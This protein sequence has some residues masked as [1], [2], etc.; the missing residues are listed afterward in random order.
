MALAKAASHVDVV[1]TTPLAGTDLSLDQ[2]A[3]PVQT[4][5]A[6]DIENSGALTWQAS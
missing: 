2:I 6:A 1:A 5:T 3:S 4:A